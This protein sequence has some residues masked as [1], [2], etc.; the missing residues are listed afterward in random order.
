MPERAGLEEKLERVRS[1]MDNASQSFEASVETLAGLLGSKDVTRISA[2]KDALNLWGDALRSL[3]EEERAIQRRLDYLTSRDLSH[4]AMKAV[5]SASRA[6][7]ATFWIAIVAIL[8]ST[9]A[10]VIATVTYLA[11]SAPN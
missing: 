5:K 3:S 10:A 4:S 7:W 11:R 9:T 2:A 8:A 6:A 1:D